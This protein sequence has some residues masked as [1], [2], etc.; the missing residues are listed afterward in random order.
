MICRARRIFLAHGIVLFMTDGQPTLPIPRRRMENARLAVEAADRSSRFDIRID[1][2]AIGR[3]A[4]DDP[5][6]TVEMARS[7]GGEYTSVRDPRDLIA[8]F[9]NLDFARIDAIEIRNATT[10]QGAPFVMVHADGSFSALVAVRDGWNDLEV[11][12]RAV[13][14][15]EATSV[16]A[17]RMLPH[18]AMPQLS[19]RLRS[20]R[21]RALESMLAGL[22]D[23]RLELEVMRADQLRKELRIEIAAAQADAREHELQRRLEITAVESAPTP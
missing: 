16:I 17:V 18:A 7:T 1:T 5:F 9:Q 8:I 15:S 14:G 12:A 4:A 23:R 21:T 13:D 6:T 22:V 19:A 11:H 20:R 2:F 10:G 3:S